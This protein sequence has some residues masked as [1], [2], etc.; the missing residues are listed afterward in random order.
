MPTSIYASPLGA[1][2]AG[3][4][5]TPGPSKHGNHHADSGL[6]V[7]TGCGWSPSC[8]NCPLP[9]CIHD[10]SQDQVRRLIHV[11]TAARKR[12]ASSRSGGG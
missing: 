10:L 2:D 4:P 7:D 5:Q 3:P 1:F 11:R 12:A 9:L 8:I 6:F